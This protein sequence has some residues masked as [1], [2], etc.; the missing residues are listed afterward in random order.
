MVFAFL[1]FDGFIDYHFL[2]F[3]NQKDELP[4]HPTKIQDSLFASQFDDCILN[5]ISF[6]VEKEEGS[7]PVVC[8][9]PTLTKDHPG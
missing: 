9:T 7:N 8:G 4:G 5:A 2:D 3:I 6:A 1:I